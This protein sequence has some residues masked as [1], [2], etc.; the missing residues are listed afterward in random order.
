MSSVPVKCLT[1]RLRNF[2]LT[3]AE[4]ELI[5]FAESSLNQNDPVS[6]MIGLILE[7]IYRQKTGFLWDSIT[8]LSE[9]QLCN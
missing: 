7:R 5:R 9:R 4:I 3:E 8:S 1:S 2:Q 6:E